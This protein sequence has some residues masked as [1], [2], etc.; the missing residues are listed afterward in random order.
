MQLPDRFCIKCG[1]HRL[2]RADVLGVCLSCQ[3]SPTVQPAPRR[4]L[5]V[6][7]E[8]QRLCSCGRGGTVY[9]GTGKCITC[10]GE[11]ARRRRARG[12]VYQ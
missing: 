5:K 3:D 8:G 4:E 2:S 9:Q 11:D 12:S 10:R 1:I 7:G 6:D